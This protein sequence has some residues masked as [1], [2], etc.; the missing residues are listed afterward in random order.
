MNWRLR[1]ANTHLL[2]GL[3][4]AAMI[5]S[6]AGTPAAGQ[7]PRSRPVSLRKPGQPRGVPS[8]DRCHGELEFLRQHT[9]TLDR[10]GAISIPDRSL[11]G[12]GH[13]FACTECHNG[14][15]AFPHLK[16]SLRT[17]TCESC[18][19]EQ[20]RAWK[21]GAHANVDRGKPVGCRDC[22]GIHTV[23][24]KDALR[25]KANVLAMNARCLGCHDAKRMAAHAPHADSVSCASCHGAHD[26]RPHDRPGSTL[27]A[28]AQ[29]KTCGACHQKVAAA[30]QTDIHGRTLLQKLAVKTEPGE[31]EPKRPPTCTSCHGAHAM[32][33][34]KTAPAGAGPGAACTKCHEK[35]ADTFADSYHGQATRLGSKLAAGCA[36]CHT[37]HSIL[38]ADSP[39]S[40]VAKGNV[41]STCA[42]CHKQASAG[43]VGFQPHADV[44]DQDKSPLLYWTY[45]FMTLLLAG[46]MTVFGIHTALW[47]ARLGIGR[48]VEKRGGPDSRGGAA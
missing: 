24:A 12:T 1:P 23:P 19:E 17:A 14:F 21:A 6:G 41:V 43:F 40:S 33:H 10:A 7:S 44:H 31:R 5:L 20:A 38:P 16:S 25:A 15:A 30:W 28:E 2:I 8:C 11:R 35:Y 4:A 13:D 42:Q 9:P 45:R 34:P 48:L 36:S 32:E 29:V 18:H 27:S 3:L 26:V 22:H 39:R 37:A 47:L 46:T